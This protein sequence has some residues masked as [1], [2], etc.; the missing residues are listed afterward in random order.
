LIDS[1]G[2]RPAPHDR[3]GVLTP[4]RT[5]ATAFIVFHAIHLFAGAIRLPFAA[6][7]DVAAHTIPGSPRQP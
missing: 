5:T 3:H 2:D 7:S 6:A 1:H 4:P